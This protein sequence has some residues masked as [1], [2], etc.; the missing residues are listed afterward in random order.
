MMSA[1]ARRKTVNIFD[2][3]RLTM[4]KICDS[5]KIRTFVRIFDLCIISVRV[6]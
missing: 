4:A 2:V 6:I 1:N 3:K 5:K